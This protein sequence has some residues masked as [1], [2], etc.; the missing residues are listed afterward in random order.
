MSA[1]AARTGLIERLRTISG[2]RV[3]T[4]EPMTIQSTPV[5]FVSPDTGTYALA[6][7]VKNADHGFAIRVCVAFQDNVIADDQLMPYIDSVPAAIRADLTLGGRA[8]VLSTIDWSAVGEDGFY[9]SG[10]PLVRFRSVVFR[11]RIKDKLAN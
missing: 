1:V 10:D 8:N 9:E 6:G 11:V 2:L 5:A 4:A 3:L 7:Q